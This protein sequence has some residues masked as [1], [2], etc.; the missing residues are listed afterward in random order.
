MSVSLDQCARITGRPAL[1]PRGLSGGVADIF[2]DGYEC[3]PP[4]SILFRMRVLF[5]RPTAVRVE[6]G[7]DGTRTLAAQA[8][9]T[10]ASWVLRTLKGKPIAF[11]DVRETGQTRMFTSTGACVGS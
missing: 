3:L 5:R 10:R 8:R 11:A 7:R 6:R 9:I 2:G 1:S 4:R